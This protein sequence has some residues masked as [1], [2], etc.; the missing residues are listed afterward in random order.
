M[1]RRGQSSGTTI[2]TTVMVKEMS[3]TKKESA[4]SPALNDGQLQ[5]EERLAPEA[6]TIPGWSF[7]VNHEDNELFLCKIC[8]GVLMDPH[9]ITCCGECICK[10]CIDCH[11]RLS[12][13]DGREKS[14]PFCRKD[15]FKL[16]ENSDLKK[17]IN[18][19]EVYCLY[20]KSGCMWQGKLKEGKAHLYEC[21][22]Y[23][24]DCP[25]KCEC[26]KIE[27]RNLRKHIAECPLQIME[28]SFEP[29]GC[30]PEY[31]LPRK[32]L[33]VHTNQD[34]HQHLIL[35][36]KSTL[37]MH[38]EFDATVATFKLCQNEELQEMCSLFYS[39]KEEFTML[40]QHIQSLEMEL[41]DLQTRIKTMKQL[42]SENGAEYTAE[43]SANYSETRD[44]QNVCHT[45]LTEFQTLPIP[46]PSSDNIFCPPVTF[47]IDRFS[48]RKIHNEMWMSPP[49][50]THTGGYK[51]CL[52]VFPNGKEEA[53]GNHISV[54]LHMMQGEFDDH[55]TWP[56]SG[57]AINIT[58][59]NQRNPALSKFVRSKGNIGLDI[60][61]FTS[62]SRE[63][64]SRVCD[65]A[66]GPGFGFKEFVPLQYLNQFLAND[67]FKI[68]IFNIQF[69]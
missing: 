11:L 33:T 2:D 53:E 22:F 12:T 6:W 21:I 29:I 16:I 39:K 35:L 52:S 44:L 28:C 69:I 9:L 45:T 31:P 63:V 65:G 30:K 60:N 20:H 42:V 66:H 57:A 17:S 37:K 18:N 15:D 23:P 38:E 1:N 64:R 68:M 26:G 7:V 43:L 61:L 50:Y 4:S 48:V 3:Q 19:L 49:F 58:A 59:L 40:E 8:M 13:I 32:E 51:M 55:L 67:T 62:D 34:I 46:A 27:R 41:L 54:Y 5:D 24:I 36:A 25:N 56:F 14:C 10:R 47:S